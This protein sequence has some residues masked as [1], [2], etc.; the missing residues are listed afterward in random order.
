MKLGMCIWGILKNGPSS[1]NRPPPQGGIFE[2]I[3]GFRWILAQMVLT[4]VGRLALQKLQKMEEKIGR[5]NGES[6]RSVVNQ[7]K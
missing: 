2:L 4:Y 7:M 1:K 6:K 5:Y 3:D